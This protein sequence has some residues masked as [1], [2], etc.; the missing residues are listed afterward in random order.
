[1]NKPLFKGIRTYASIILTASVVLAEYF[2]VIDEKTAASLVAILSAFGLY[3][4]SKA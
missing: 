3:F 4:R 2:G 1:M